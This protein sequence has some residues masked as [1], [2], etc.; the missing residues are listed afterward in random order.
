MS[1]WIPCSES[2]PPFDQQVLAFR[3]DSNHLRRQKYV[4][5]CLVYRTECTGYIG[6]NNKGLD[7]KWEE[8]GAMKHFGWEMTHWQPITT[9]EPIVVR[10]IQVIIEKYITGH[11]T[12]G[13][14]QDW[15]A[16]HTWELG[17]DAITTVCK[18]SRMIYSLQLLI[19]EYDAGHLMRPDFLRELKRIL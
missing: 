14:L 3:P 19:A 13:D 2:L 7:Y 9:Y 6:G 15:L 16:P 5:V 18:V 4:H 8:F 1:N 11:V 10:D 12:L 17:N